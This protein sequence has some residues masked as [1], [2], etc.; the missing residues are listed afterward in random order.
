[1]AGNEQTTRRHLRLNGPAR[2]MAYRTTRY[3]DLTAKSN[4]FQNRT[5]FPSY[6][7][8]IPAIRLLGP[9]DELSQSGYRKFET[10]PVIAVEVP[11]VVHVCVQITGLSKVQEVQLTDKKCLMR[12]QR[13]IVSRC[14]RISGYGTYQRAPRVVFMAS[15][16]PEVNAISSYDVLVALFQ[17]TQ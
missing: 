10:S 4:A 12:L 2:S 11:C 15:G 16:S 14:V 5:G 6:S 13:F 3:R 7:K 8:R 1:M 17:I 9:I